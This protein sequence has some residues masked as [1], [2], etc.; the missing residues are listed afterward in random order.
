MAL[1]IPEIF[2]TI[3]QPLAA[4]NYAHAKTITPILNVANNIVSDIGWSGYSV[5]NIIPLASLTNPG[6]NSGFIR[7]RFST[8]STTS[9]ANLNIAYVGAGIASPNYDFDGSQ[10]QLFF[11]GAASVN[12][13]NGA[14]IFT[15]DFA[16]FTFNFSTAVSLIVSTYW[17]GTTVDA[18]ADFTGPF[19][20]ATKY[21]LEAIGQEGVSAPTGSWAV[22]G[23]VFLT[24]IEFA[25]N[26][27]SFVAGDT[28]TEY[29]TLN[30]PLGTGTILSVS[31]TS[32]ASGTILVAPLSGNLQS[33]IVFFNEGN[34]VTANVSL[35][36]DQTA[37]G[38]LL[39]VPTTMTL[40]YSSASGIFHEGDAV[41]E[42]DPFGTEIANGVISNVVFQAI[43]LVNCSTVFWSNTLVITRD[44]GVSANVLSLSLLVGLTSNTSFT[45]LPGNWCFGPNFFTS[46]NVLATSSG[47]GAT[48]Q[49]GTLNNEELVSLNTDVILLY[50]NV[51]LNAADYGAGL[52]HAN[53][54]TTL[55]AA[56]NYTSVELGTIASLTGVNPGSDYSFAPI[57][58]IYEPLTIDYFEED[59][60]FHISQPTGIFQVGESI[61]Q[62]NV[63]AVGIVK[64]ADSI[65]VHVQRIQ[66]ENFWLA[67][68]HI[69]DSS[70]LLHGSSSGA[71]ANLDSYISDALSPS[72]GQNAEV[73]ANTEVA[74]G[75]VTALEVISSGFCF[76]QGDI[77]T[78]ASSDG[79]RKGTAF[80]VLNNQGVSP[81]YY[82]DRKGWTSADQKL[83]DSYYWQQY[84]YDIKSA[85]SPNLYE[86]MLKSLLH[87]AGKIHFS[88]IVRQ[89]MVTGDSQITSSNV[90]LT[91]EVLGHIQ[92][93]FTKAPHSQYIPN[94]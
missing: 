59:Y 43:T 24:E 90:L 82:K 45:N 58:Y 57:V 49:I 40:N 44:T 30:I 7:V 69:H 61:S 26:T 4:L 23:L 91:A 51:V 74:N 66:F 37:T 42:L 73:I 33:N 75:T 48:F 35:Y 16:P 85:I 89:S 41:Y 81:G 1:L 14:T 29:N 94:L 86:S 67:N 25:S 70:Y 55:L 64:S 38:S 93:N 17:S 39:Q 92:L 76:N 6:F 50:E 11:G 13:I 22:D 84:S 19:A 10:V 34:A 72:I 21:R 53:S 83:L 18:T 65:S 60:I 62:P 3:T 8:A 52:H 79:L 9:T 20:T 12:P 88:S 27:G 5:R 63:G 54:A 31:N 68:N 28:L 80:A 71:T 87:I 56:L 46:A 36:T 77:A 78:F 15:S 2:D 47:S 32:G